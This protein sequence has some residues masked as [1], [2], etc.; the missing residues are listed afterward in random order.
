MNLNN[1]PFLKNVDFS[2]RT[3]ILKLGIVVVGVI[4]AIVLIVVILRTPDAGTETGGQ[5]ESAVVAPVLDIQN[6]ED[7]DGIERKTNVGIANEQ[8]RGTLADILFQ[9]KDSAVVDDPLA[10]LMGEKKD[11]PGRDARSGIR[12]GDKDIFPSSPKAASA[13]TLPDASIEDFRRAAVEQQKR[14]RLIAMGIDPDTGLPL[15]GKE[16]PKRSGSSSPAPAAT[17]PAPAPQQTAPATEPA[18]NPEIVTNEAASID[19]DDSFGLGTTGINS[20]TSQSKNTDKLAIKVMFIEE[21]KVKSGDRVQLRLCEEKGIT[22]EGVH[23]PKNSLLYANVQ[24][25]DRLLIN[26]PSVN[27]NGRILPL[28]LEAYDVDGLQGIYCPTSTASE[29]LRE[30]G[31]EVKDIAAGT[32]SGVMNSFGARIVNLGRN[33]SER[34]GSQS[35]AYITSG[36]T[37]NLMKSDY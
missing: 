34:G 35:Y 22:V 5:A 14:D 26:V 29:A 31:R 23:I 16:A 32:V 25:A 37:F 11:E 33:A 9:K 3:N 19:D 21:R 27:I 17:V 20:L 7:N 13:S 1:I 12:P 10:T 28:K 18:V 30:A 36:Y 2:D 8:K 15:P 24:L 4:V 6:G